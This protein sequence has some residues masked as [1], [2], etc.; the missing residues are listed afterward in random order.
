MGYLL[1][2]SSPLGAAPSTITLP[3]LLQ[4]PHCL[5]HFFQL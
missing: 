1:A 5:S 3:A 2:S 4:V